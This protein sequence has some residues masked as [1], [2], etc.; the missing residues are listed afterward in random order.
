M[1]T[2][3]SSKKEVDPGTVLGLV[4]TI[5]GFLRP[6][7]WEQARESNTPVDNWMLDMLDKLLGFSD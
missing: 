6:W 4:K 2:V 5:Y 3:K 1:M 7:L